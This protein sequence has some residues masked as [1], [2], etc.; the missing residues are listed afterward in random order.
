MAVGIEMADIR[1]LRQDERPGEIPRVPADQVRFAHQ[2]PGLDGGGVGVAGDDIGEAVFGQGMHLDVR[3]E[4]LGIVQE[5]AVAPVVGMAGPAV[6]VAQPHVVQ[7]LPLHV[8]APALAVR[9]HLVVHPGV[10]EIVAENAPVV[11]DVLVPL[12]PVPPVTQPE[13]DEIAARTGQVVEHFPRQ[14]E[15][16]LRGEIGHVIGAV[17]AVHG[18]REVP[19][20]QV[21]EPAVGPLEKMGRARGDA[22]KAGRLPGRDR[23]AALLQDAVRGPR[24]E[25]AIGM[26]PLDPGAEAEPE[27]LGAGRADLLAFQPVH[28]D[29][30]LE[31]ERQQAPAFSARLDDLAPHGHLPVVERIAVPAGQVEFHLEARPQRQAVGGRPAPGERRLPAGRRVSPD[32]Q[33][34]IG[35]DKGGRGKHLDFQA[36]QSGA[37]P[38]GP[39]AR[40]ADRLPV[41]LIAQEGHGKGKAVRGEAGA[42]VEVG[43]AQV[44]IPHREHLDGAARQVLP[45]DQLE[46]VLAGAIH[47]GRGEGNG[48]DGLMRGV[49]PHR[50]LKPGR[51]GRQDKGGANRRQAVPRL[52][53]IQP[54][55]RS[56][57]IQQRKQQPP[58]DG[59]NELHE[60][61]NGPF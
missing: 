46:A 40:V 2:V 15:A 50:G 48:E 44:V 16:A 45:G 42:A 10:L 17:G 51:F 53:G 59:G 56:G 41:H 13:P 49:A 58:S 25:Q 3:P 1:H 55:Q 23:E 11:V 47:V 19:A 7:R 21:D 32:A 22:Q 29:K 18:I 35:G 38:G 24:E 34:Q 4:L 27:M 54:R 37:F 30:I 12:Q 33:L 6:G 8:E 9:H 60:G 20:Q 28:R 39:G 26:G 43:K 61:V 5:A 31:E 52:P 57:R 14:G 36:A